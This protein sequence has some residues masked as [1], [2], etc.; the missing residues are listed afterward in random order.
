MM[1]PFHRQFDIIYFREFHEF[2]KGILNGE[3]VSG[4]MKNQIIY[5]VHF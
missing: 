2:F 3:E 5:S 4:L 1:R